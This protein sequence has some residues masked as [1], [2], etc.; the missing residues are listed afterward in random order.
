MLG[1][2]DAIAFDKTGTLTSGEPRIRQ[3]IPA[4]GVTKEE[5][6]AIAVAVESLSGHPLAQAIARD[7]KAHV[8]TFADLPA[9]DL[10]SLTG[11]GVSARVEGELI[12][13]GKAEM[14]G[15][16]GVEPLSQP[17]TDAIEQ[18]RQTGHTTM[19]V[20]RGDQ[21]L[22]AIGLMD[23]PREAARAT[24]ERLHAIGIRRMIM[25]SGDKKRPMLCDYLP[26]YFPE[27]ERFAG[28]SR[29]D[30][31]LA[32]IERFPTPASMT[33]TLFDSFVGARR[34]GRVLI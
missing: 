32:L 22:G 29:S 7:G 27:I 19:V 26:L 33:A 24:I 30:W 8:G 18:L 11:R 13:I 21:D 16:D 31:F 14:F 28:N 23:T 15:A 2:L 25:I 6:M 5:L 17:M 20:R 34:Q 12:L 3:I 9:T 1:S 4:S 10:K